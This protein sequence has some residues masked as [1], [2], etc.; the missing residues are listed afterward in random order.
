MDEIL[1]ASFRAEETFAWA[2]WSPPFAS[3]FGGIGDGRGGSAGFVALGRIQLVRRLRK[4]RC[5]NPPQQNGRVAHLK[6]HDHTSVT[7]DG[8]PSLIPRASA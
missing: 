4:A 8:S 7:D 3:S 1:S 5:R 2:S 6:S